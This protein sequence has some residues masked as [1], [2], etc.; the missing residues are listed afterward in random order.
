MICLDRG[1]TPSNWSSCSRKY[2]EDN[3]ARGIGSCLK[4][5]PMKVEGPYCGNG[6]LEDGEECDCGPEEFCHNKCCIATACKLSVNGN[7]GDSCCKQV[8]VINHVLVAA[9]CGHG[10][11][12]DL[13]TCSIKKAATICRE[14]PS[15]ECDLPEYCDGKAGTC[16]DDFWKDDGTKCRDGQVRFLC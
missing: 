8:V 15:D 13:D 14:R 12:C 7:D 10:S 1:Q 3:L 4:R 2:L 5:V 9:T 6:F 11:C 16:P